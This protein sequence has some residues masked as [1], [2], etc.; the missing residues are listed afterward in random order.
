MFIT[1]ESQPNSNLLRRS[2]SAFK[3]ASWGEDNPEHAKDVYMELGSS[4]LSDRMILA[5][6]PNAILR[7]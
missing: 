1:T 5:L 7:M 6:E 4:Y 2:I 3:I